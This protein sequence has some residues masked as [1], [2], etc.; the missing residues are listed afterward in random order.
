MLARIYFSDTKIFEL[1]DNGYIQ[2]QSFKDQIT[3]VDEPEE[4]PREDHP[5]EFYAPLVGTRHIDPKN[6]LTYQTVDIKTTPNR[7][8]VAWRR[9]IIRGVLQ[10]T[11]QG[12]FHVHDIYTYTQQTLKNGML[13]ERHSVAISPSGISHRVAPDPDVIARDGP[14]GVVSPTS[15]E[16]VRLSTN[17]TLRS[18]RSLTNM[19]Q[20]VD[21]RGNATPLVPNQTTQNEWNMIT[22]ST[23][24][25]KN[26][27]RFKRFRVTTHLA[28]AIA[29]GA[30]YC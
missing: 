25:K 21:P 15:G 5:V 7:D 14:S 12:P 1:H 9:R 26:V 18:K 24:D 6:G 17:G 20:N 22:T 11:S 4:E 2:Y 16:T 29:S 13:N 28:S 10:D 23:A 8:I 27:E 30:V 19:Q 3:G